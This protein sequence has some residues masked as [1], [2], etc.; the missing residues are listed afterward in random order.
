MTA[1]SL[2]VFLLHN[3]TRQEYAPM[4][5]SAESTDEL[6]DEGKLDDEYVCSD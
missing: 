6:I 3:E 5:M 2:S 4:G 1:G